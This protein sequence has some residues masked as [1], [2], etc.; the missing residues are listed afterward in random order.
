MYNIH[1]LINLNE[2]SMMTTKQLFFNYQLFL[3]KKVWLLAIVVMLISS[4]N[5][6]AQQVKVISGIVTSVKEGIPLPGVNVLVKGTSTGVVTDFDGNYQIEVAQRD[7]VLIFSYLG[8]KTKEVPVESR[9]TIDVSLAEDIESLSEVVVI[10][11]GTQKKSD[12]TGAISL[13]KQE[14]YKEQPVIRVDQIL[15]GRSAGVSVI[16]TSGAPGGASQIRIRGANSI[17]GN[18]DPLYV[19]DGFVGVDFRDVNPIDIETIQVL[20]DA[21]STAIYGSRGANGVVL[22]TTK[23]GAAGKQK[24]SVYARY[25]TASPLDTWDL[26]DAGIFAETANQR[27]ATMGTSPYFTSDQISKFKAE[28]G[29]D[30][31]DELLRIAGGEEIQLDY[32]G[33]ND[34]VTYF[35]SGNYLDQDGIVINSDYKRISLRTN[36]SAKITEKLKTNLR[37]NFVRRENNNTEGNYTNSGPLAGTMGWAPTTPAYD[38]VG[39]L[40]VRDPI[41]SIRGNPIEL[42]LDDNINENNVFIANG[43]FTYDIIKGLVLDIGF[44]FNYSNTQY[45]GY[46][47]NSMSSSPNATRQST[48]RLFFQNTNLLTYDKIFSEDHH[49]TLT[50]VLETQSSQTD[51]FTVTASNLQFPELKYDNISLASALSANA[52]KQKQTILSYIARANYSFR[53]KY[54]LTASVRTDGSSKFRGDNRYSTFPAVGAGWRLSEEGFMQDLG[55]FDN[56]KLRASWGET[57]SQAIPTYGTVTTF[58]TSPFDA[59]TSFQNGTQTAGI[60]VG[61]PGNENLTWETTAQTNIG[62]DFVIFNSRLSGEI[63]YYNK[64]TTDLLV[65]EPL[66]QYSGG[67]SINRNL[68]EVNNSGFEITLDGVI[69]KQKNFQWNSSLSAAFSHNEVVSIGDREEIFL[70]GDAGSGLTNLP[71]MVIMPG[72][73]LSNYWGL[74]YLGVW[75]TNEAA[76]AAKFGLFPGDSR[77]EDL[78]KDGVFGGDDYQIIGTGIPTGTFGWNNTLDYKNFTLNFFFQSITGFDKWNFGYAQAMAGSI[79][80]R[81]ITHVDI[82]NRWSPTNTGSNIPAFSKTNV[83]E[84]QS[85]RFV[86]K[87]DYIRLKNLSLTYNLPKDLIKGV[88]GSVSVIG[89]NL[90]TITNYTGIDPETS[91]NVGA[92]QDARGADAGSYPNAKT[93]TFGINLIF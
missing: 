32:S 34:K 18:N 48:E 88:N 40:T 45:K 82:L 26:M 76:E 2:I 71:E 74:K 43:N 29:T 85:S 19:V 78:N 61:N 44:G 24:F 16:N 22:I 13:I 5:L 50:G 90:W 12:L 38:A 77:Y 62:L 6:S 10:G 35:I 15:Q 91:S 59:G 30:W 52:N 81:Q 9:T 11:Y 39:K 56:L 54:L 55:F 60:I 80:A 83:T 23:N 53:E 21:S 37:M 42:A 86:E 3:P 75:Q 57:G 20:K 33:G 4:Y 25:V 87:G 79:D 46:G 66:A 67:G 93:W 28:G 36:V 27:A 65:S 1:L 70:D 51:I 68:G 89:T 69:I 72:Y 49:L 92:N 63:D 58:Y 8:F 84:I 7:V 64:N 14:S 41:G 73:S 47:A 31:Q 17:N